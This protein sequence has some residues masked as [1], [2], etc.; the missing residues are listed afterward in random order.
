M[1]DV[2]VEDVGTYRTTVRTGAKMAQYCAFNAPPET[3]P[4]VEGDTILISFSLSMYKRKLTTQN[5][6][7]PVEYN[8]TKV[9]RMSGKV[10]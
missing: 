7:T 1:I 3:V 4:L 8:L 5:P 9:G 2:N 6:E 10:P